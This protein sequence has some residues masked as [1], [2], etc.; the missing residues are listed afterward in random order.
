MARIANYWNSTSNPTNT[1]YNSVTIDWGW[2]NGQTFSNRTTYKYTELTYYNQKKPEVRIN[3]VDSTN[4]SITLNDKNISFK[5]YTKD[6]DGNY[7]PVMNDA[8]P[9]AQVT[10][11]AQGGSVSTGILLEAGTDYYFVED[12]TTVPAGYLD[13]NS[14][15]ADI[16]ALYTALGSNY[17]Y[18]TIDGQTVLVIKGTMQDRNKTA[19]SSSDK[20]INYCTFTFKNIP[21]S[22]SILVHKKIDGQ[23]ATISGFPVVVL[24]IKD[25]NCRKKLSPNQLKI[26]QKLKTVNLNQH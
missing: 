1:D 24:I 6:D 4:S 18:A 26:C 3:K 17:T 15:S 11:T 7:V 13:P 23:A 14:T 8:T 16:Q 5:V 10:V 19:P 25:F 2:S 21:N 22:G 9:P 20:A 12:S